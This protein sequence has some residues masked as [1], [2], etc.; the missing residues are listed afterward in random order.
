MEIPAGDLRVVGSGLTLFNN[1]LF[2]EI[3]VNKKQKKTNKKLRILKKLQ[4]GS[5]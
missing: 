2:I 1:M 3:I 5:Y 4:I